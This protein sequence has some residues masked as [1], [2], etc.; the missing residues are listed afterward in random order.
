MCFDLHSWS[1]LLRSCDGHSA[2]TLGKQFHCLLIKTGSVSS[3][4][5][6]NRI[7]QVYSRFAGNAALGD[8]RQ[9]FDEMPHRNCFSYNTLI[10]A[11]LKAKDA[12]NSLWLF[13]AMTEKNAYSWNTIISGLVK[14]GDI[15]DARKVFDKMP[16]RDVI[17]CNSIIY[18]YIKCGKVQ[19]AFSLYKRLDFDSPS[20]CNDGFVMATM[21]SA[22]AD[23]LL[24][25]CGK[26]IHSRIVVHGIEIDSVLGSALVNMY[27]KCGDLDN[28]HR[29]SELMKEPDEFSLSALI[30]GYA[31]SGRLID[32]RIVFD[33]RMNPG[34]VLWNSMINGY[35]S[36][37]RGEEA[38]HLFKRMR[39]H[40]VHAD[41]S[42][43]ASVLSGCVSTGMLNNG[44]QMHGFA[45][46]HGFLEDTVVASALLDA[47]SKFG[48]WEDACIVFREIR[49]HDTILLNSMINVY[50][51][52]GRIEDARR[53]FETI[54]SKSLI[55]W[56][57][58][59]VG[60]SQ[61]GYAVE[62]LELFCEMHRIDLRPDKVALA[63]AISAAASVCS[64][65]L[66]EQIFALT[67]VLGLIL[68]QIISTSLVDLYCKCGRVSDGRRLFDSMIKFD[69]APWNSMLMGYSMNG[70][71]IEVLQLFEVM[72]SA[73][74]HPNEVS[75]I[76]V[77]SGCCHC[78]ILEEGL[79]WFQ[80]MKE[81]YGIEP[82]VEHYSCMV[83][84]LVR[85]GRLEEAVNFIEQMPFEADASMWTSVLGGCKA[86]GDELL[87]SRLAKKLMELNPQQSGPYVQLS[88]LYASHGEWERSTLMRRMMHEKR[89][90]KK[91]GY[92]WIDN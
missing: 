88:G 45:L 39:R 38:L 58:M 25:S 8:A 11:Y 33:C 36:N 35:V 9:L 87:A 50:A 49:V 29:V 41:F 77:L 47:Y 59:I 28:A 4:F 44:K 51:N 92:S 79:T 34:V 83:D 52:C 26:Q 40:G 2:I 18:G 31:R 63:S 48:S 56:N 5:D 7:L 62:A 61:N 81:D 91:P 64:L 67:M 54:P 85:A 72:R 16:D 12:K 66:G 6:S 76:A 90:N 23:C 13:D 37:N 27:G 14:L 32:A 53:V 3:L 70:Y 46:K 22:C 20:P 71:G 73:G 78:G 15:D 55:S 19:E 89:I 82:V 60:Y 86:Q 21:V 69:V 57:S 74:V 10:D 42:T 17:A 84:L 30:G 68:D 1:R 65:R 24:Y 75:F 80:T 43:L